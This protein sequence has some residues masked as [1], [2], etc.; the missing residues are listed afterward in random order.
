MRLEI[1]IEIDIDSG[2]R[3]MIPGAKRL[4]KLGVSDPSSLFV[5]LSIAHRDASAYA[6]E[7]SESSFR[8]AAELDADMWEIDIRM[9]ADG[10]CVVS[11]DA[12]TVADSGKRIAIA[13]STWTELSDVVRS[14]GRTL[15]TLERVI[16]LAGELKRGLYLE[17]KQSGSEMETWRLLEKHNFRNA[18]IGSFI[19][20]VVQTLRQTGCDFPLS[21]LVRAG[22][23]PFIAAD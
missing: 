13:A 10:I 23:D 15:L 8:I 17:I 7:N 2:L 12:D 1:E 14:N 20:S 16:E 22:H 5:P 9:S 18:V 19:T 6:A 21:I 11:H 4:A 3:H